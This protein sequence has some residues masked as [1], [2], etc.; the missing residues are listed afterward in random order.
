VYAKPAREGFLRKTG[1][2]TRIGRTFQSMQENDL[3]TRYIT[4]SEQRTMF[5]TNYRDSF[6]DFILTANGG[7]APFVYFTGPEIPRDCEKVRVSEDGL[8]II[9][10]LWVIR[11]LRPLEVTA[12]GRADADFLAFLY[13]RRYLHY[14]SRIH[15][16]SFGYVRNSGAFDAGLGL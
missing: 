1:N 7:K 12:V 2:V 16:G 13:E 3:A 6:R 9:A 10:Q 15:L 5:Q 4:W 8:E 14:Q 11:S